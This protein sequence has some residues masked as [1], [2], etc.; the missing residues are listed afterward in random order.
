MVA[1][2]SAA[3]ERQAA[4]P[5]AVGHAPAVEELVAQ[6]S[7]TAAAVETPLRGKS[8]HFGKRVAFASAVIGSALIA[9]Y[10]LTP[11]EYEETVILEGTVGHSKH[12]P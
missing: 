5:F 12:T 6:R 7:G 2:V 4:R 10:L 11:R 1:E 8:L 9:L 3:D